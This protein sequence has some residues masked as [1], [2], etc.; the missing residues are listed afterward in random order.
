[1]TVK[2]AEKAKTNEGVGNG[3]C[4]VSVKHLAGEGRVRGRKAI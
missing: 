4:L 3:A 2:F 1:L